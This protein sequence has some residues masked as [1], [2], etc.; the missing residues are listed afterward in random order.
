MSLIPTQAIIT[1][2]IKGTDLDKAPQTLSEALEP[3]PDARIVTVTQKT[4]WMTSM[5]GE[6]SLLAVIE[7]NAVSGHEHE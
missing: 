3:Y 7:Y 4:N 2:T 1:A 6:T 5:R